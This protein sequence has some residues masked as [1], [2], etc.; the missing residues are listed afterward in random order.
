MKLLQL[1]VG[2]E[3]TIAGQA[4]VH[5]LMPTDDQQVMAAGTLTVQNT[6]TGGKFP[7]PENVEVVLFN[8]V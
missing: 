3:F 4:D 1:V 2:D 7:L 8:F 5:K 6:R